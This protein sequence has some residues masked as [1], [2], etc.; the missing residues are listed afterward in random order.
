MRVTR[1]AGSSARAT[2]SQTEMVSSTNATTLTG[3]QSRRRPNVRRSHTG[4]WPWLSNQSRSTSRSL[5][6]KN[7][8]ASSA[9][10]RMTKPRTAPSTLRRLG[11]G[12]AGRDPASCVIV[13]EYLPASVAADTG[14]A[15]PVVRGRKHGRTGRSA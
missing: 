4:S 7:R 14:G 3:I 15:H 1:G 5:M 2:A 12:Q 6:V 13:F 10:P 9:R 8:S 11:S